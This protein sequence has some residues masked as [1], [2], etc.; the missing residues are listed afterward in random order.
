[1]AEVRNRVWNVTIGMGIAL[2]LGYV[3]VSAY[4]VISGKLP[5][6]QFIADVKPLI[7]L[8]IGSAVALLKPSV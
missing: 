7:T 8:W 6:P 3:G 5:A 1:M 4:M 2:T